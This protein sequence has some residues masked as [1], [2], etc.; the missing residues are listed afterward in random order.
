LTNKG[1]SNHH[2]RLRYC[3]GGVITAAATCSSSTTTTTE[4]IA[5]IIRTVGW[6]RLATRGLVPRMCITTIII[7]GQ[8]VLY[9]TFKRLLLQ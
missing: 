7:T 4:S 2:H 1:H 8:W 5:S 6:Y 9:G 3:N